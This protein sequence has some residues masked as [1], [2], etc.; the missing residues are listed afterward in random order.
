MLC[1]GFNLAVLYITVTETDKTRISIVA[2]KGKMMGLF[3]LIGEQ[4]FGARVHLHPVKK[5]FVK[6]SEQFKKF[7]KKLGW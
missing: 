1:N 3:I 7:Q 4:R 2:I 6:N 5:K